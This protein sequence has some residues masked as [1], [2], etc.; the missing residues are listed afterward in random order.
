MENQ[1]YYE[2]DYSYLLK[3]EPL[4]SLLLSENGTIHM[5]MLNKDILVQWDSQAEEDIEMNMIK[6][7]FAIFL[8]KI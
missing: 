3:P 8:I 7:C 2:E 5:K 6:E 4:P 1:Q